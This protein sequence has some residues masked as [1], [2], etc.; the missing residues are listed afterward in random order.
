V[1]EQPAGRVTLV[2]TDIE[3]STRL[4]DEMGQER[5]WAALA[6]HREIIRAAFQAFAGY[7]VDYEGDAFFYAFSL[8]AQAVAAVSEG[9][10]A[11]AGGPVRIRV[12]VHTGEPGLDPPKYVG[13]DVAAEAMLAAV[14]GISTDSARSLLAR[15]GSVADVLAADM[16]ALLN[17]PG[18]GPHRASAIHTTLHQ[19]HSS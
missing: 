9:V 6:R 5:Y 7:E 13:M 17:T 12:G 19:R 2:F 8:A 4:L 11:L 16:D 18:I 15:F 1:V 3:G 10:V 14:P